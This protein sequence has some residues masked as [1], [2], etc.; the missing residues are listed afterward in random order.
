[1]PNFIA[2]LC[3][4]HISLISVSISANEGFNQWQAGWPTCGN[5]QPIRK[6]CLVSLFILLF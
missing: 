2:K 1:M 4:R 6:A 3:G 5:I